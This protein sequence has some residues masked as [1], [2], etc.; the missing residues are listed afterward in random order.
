MK[1]NKL[2]T[3]LIGAISVAIFSAATNDSLDILA[4]KHIKDM[5][6]D[7]SLTNVLL[8]LADSKDICN[9]WGH[10][11]RQVESVNGVDRLK[12]TRC[13]EKMR[14]KPEEFVPDTTP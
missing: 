9:M 3:L 5:R 2:K 1:N 6:E 4:R 11:W 7:G 12:C 10:V 14:R 13:G 8:R